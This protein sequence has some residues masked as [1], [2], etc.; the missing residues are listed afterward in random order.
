MQLKVFGLRFSTLLTMKLLIL[1]TVIASLQSSARGYGQTVTLS[2]ENATLERAFKEIKKQTGYSFVYTRGQ[3]KNT[4]PVTCQIKNGNLKEVLELCFRDQPLSY[5]IEDRYIVVQTKTTVTLQTTSQR[6][7]IDI[8]GKVVNEN[9]EAL[10]GVTITA[11]KS[12]KGAFTNERGEFSL[13]GIDDDD[14]LTLTSIGYHREDIPVNKQ[15][16]MLIKLRIAVGT[17]DETMVIAYG[18]TTKRLSTS[19]ISKVTSEEIAKQPVT[20]PLAILQGRV[21]GL[22]VTS[23]SGLPG[24]SLKIQIRGQG[25]LNATLNQLNPFDQPL[26]II[27]GVPFAPQNSN[28]NQ[29][30]SLASP[31][32]NEIYGNPYGGISPFNNINTSD[33]ESIEILRDADA[34]AI[35]GSRGANG[36]VLITTKKGKAGKAKFAF[37]IYTGTSHVTRTMPLMNTEQYLSMRKQAFSNDGISPSTILFDPSYA[38]D[39]LVFDSTRYVDWKK[40]FLGG[41]SHITDINANLSGG[42]STTQ[43]LIGAGFRNESYIFP[44]DFGNKV[45]SANI[46]LHHNSLNR[47][48]SIDF[49]ANY[50]YTQNNSSGSPSALLAYTLPPNYPNLLT[51]NGGLNWEYKGIDLYDNPIS[52]LKQKYLLQAYNLISH[53]QMKYEL[54]PGLSIL[55]SIGY[56]TLNSNEKSLAPKSSQ[57]PAQ[58]PTSYASFGTND[59]RGWI[60]E[61]QIQYKKISGRQK[62][63]ILAGATSQQNTNSKLDIFAYNYSNDNLLGS[64]SGASD[65]Y[66]S[67]AFSQYK[68]SGLFGRVNYIFNNRYIVNINGRRDGSSRFGPDRQFGNFGSLASAWLFSEESY[69]KKHL[70]IISYGK[71]RFSYGSTGN[72][73]IGDYQYLS[74]WSPVNPYQG[75]NSYLP[76]NLFNPDFSW[77]TTRKLELGLELGFFKDRILTNMTFYR[78]R[79]KNQ[80][81]TYSLPS[82]TGFTGITSNFPALIQNSGLELQLS[83]TNANTKNFSWTSSLNLTIPRNKLISF[84]GIENTPYAQKYVVGKSLNVLNTFRFLGV[85][86]TT[87]IYLFESKDGPT[88]NPVRVRDYYVFG[89]LDPKFYGGLTNTLSYK[90]FQ[91]YALFQFAKQIGPNYLQQVNNFSPPGAMYNLPITLLNNWEKTLDK[92][93]IQKF[94]SNNGT[95]AGSAATNFSSSDGAY[96]DASYLRLKALSFSYALPDIILKKLKMETAKIYLNAQNLFTIT[97]YKGNN[98]ETQSFYSLPPLRTIVAG[99]QLTF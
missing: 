9:G 28:I 13:K 22:V 36:V 16:S 12:N 41:T 45:G 57:D 77:A 98:P 42:S 4:L 17:L 26:F 47:R 79:S 92:S 46:N 50:S 81:I 21:P 8:I 85:N 58:F 70:R 37:S 94:T 99:L 68:Y 96:S 33:I 10:A 93:E 82:Q 76:Q 49:S 89:D 56:N 84:P 55:T 62:W 23:T 75:T 18:T 48:F 1:L 95:I 71:L 35:Y 44:G 67:D 39:L 14:M 73:N 64:I 43:F 2:L 83:T 7:A 90:G 25:S 29:Y 15:T 30:Q 53:L 86:D 11:K 72:D 40:Y 24:S 61:P 88:S 31:G 52:Y 59:F 6:P 51:S 20:N 3:L 69:T 66:T 54:I 60:I 87:G 19:S 65:I 38:P 91:L 63:E 5:L 27:D 80:L 97:N 74:R 32:T 78:H 34:T